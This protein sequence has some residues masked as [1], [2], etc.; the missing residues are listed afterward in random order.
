MT[1]YLAPV[2]LKLLILRSDLFGSAENQLVEVYKNVAQMCG[3]KGVMSMAEFT[4][5][6]IFLLLYG[7]KGGYRLLISSV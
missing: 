7:L 1:W 2:D 5:G 3:I 6:C 4:V